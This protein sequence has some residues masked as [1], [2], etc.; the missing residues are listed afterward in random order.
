MAMGIVLD[1]DQVLPGLVHHG[2][3]HT[4]F[5]IVVLSI[6]VWVATRDRLAFVVSLAA[7]TSHLVLDT[8]ATQFGI[9]WLWPLSTH[10]FV[11]WT[12][13]DLAAL[14]VI[15][16]F[17]FLIPA[18]WMWDTYKRTGESPLA[19]LEW[20]EGHIPRP[21]VYGG[22]ATFGVTMVFVWWTYYA[23]MLTA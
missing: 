7:L 4:P 19:V 17:A 1:L 5:L 9:M 12:L 8:V 22:V 2:W 20:V 16:V 15:K 18:Y 23:W 6:I 3:V 21:V 11:I 13:D 14:A 10:E